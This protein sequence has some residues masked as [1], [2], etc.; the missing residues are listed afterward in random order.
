MS[1][2]Y[3]KE[4]QGFASWILWLVGM[5]TLFGVLALVFSMVNELDQVEQETGFLEGRE[6]YLLLSIGTFLALF[7]VNL[8]IF[9]SRLILEIK[10]GSLF[11]RFIPIHFSLKKIRREEIIEWKVRKINPLFESRGFGYKWGY[12]K[13][14]MI[15]KGGWVLTIRRNN[16]PMLNFGT[17]KHEELRRKMEKLMNPEQEY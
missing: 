3:F 12:N 2:A 15:M 14:S 7:A 16:A 4:E 13:R 6:R 9:K 8:M 17:Q 11:Y 10:D 1:S 5:V